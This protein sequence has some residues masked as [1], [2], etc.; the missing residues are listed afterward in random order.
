MRSI[1][2]SVPDLT[3]VAEELAEAASILNGFNEAFANI[4]ARERLP[5]KNALFRAIESIRQ[6]LTQMDARLSSLLSSAFVESL[7]PK[8]TLDGSIVADEGDADDDATA[9]A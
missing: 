9:K 8:L 4:E 3:P 5:L 1:C 7:Y 2:K 6:A